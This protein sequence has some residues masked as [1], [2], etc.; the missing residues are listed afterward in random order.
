ML[1][2]LLIRCSCQCNLNLETIHEPTLHEMSSGILP[3]DGD[4]SAANFPY[5]RCRFLDLHYSRV[6]VSQQ[7]CGDLQ[8]PL[9]RRIPSEQDQIHILL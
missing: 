9:L 5:R 3:V 2:I 6:L 7:T 8:P 4:A 1:I